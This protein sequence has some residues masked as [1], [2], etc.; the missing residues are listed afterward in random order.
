MVMKSARYTRPQTEPKLL[1]I[2]K[3]PEVASSQDPQM[4]VKVV[5]KQQIKKKKHVNQGKLLQRLSKP[6]KHAKKHSSSGSALKEFRAI[7]HLISD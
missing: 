3:A 2:Q 7:G 1:S 6:I 5:I 4:S